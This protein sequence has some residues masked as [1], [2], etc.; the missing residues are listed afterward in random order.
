M[1]C[2]GIFAIKIGPS[3]NTCSGP[4]LI[5]RDYCVYKCENDDLPY[6][7]STNYILHFS[8]EGFFFVKTAP[9]PFAWWWTLSFPDHLW[10]PFTCT[11]IWITCIQSFYLLQKNFWNWDLLLAFICVYVINVVFIGALIEV[12]HFRQ[13][14]VLLVLGLHSCCHLVTGL[15][16][17]VTVSRHSTT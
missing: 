3:P 7:N 17:V 11:C 16:H 2:Y 14:P 13:D 15:S 9:L 5:P 4:S 6:S 12:D 8:S 10:L 1:F